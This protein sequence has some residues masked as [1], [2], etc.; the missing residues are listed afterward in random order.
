MGMVLGIR[1]LHSKVR[2]R[3]GWNLRVTHVAT[4]GVDGL[5]DLQSVIL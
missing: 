3:K 5:K 1:T 2:T 4:Y